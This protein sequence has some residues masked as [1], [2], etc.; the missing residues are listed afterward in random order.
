MGSFAGEKPDQII[1]NH[2]LNQMNKAS[3]P[4]IDSEAKNKIVV[5]RL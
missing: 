3:V 4:S 5:P 1:N 2:V